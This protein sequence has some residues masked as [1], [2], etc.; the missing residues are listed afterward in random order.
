MITKNRHSPYNAEVR[1][2]EEKRQMAT[3]LE[4]ENADYYAESVIF[5]RF[6]LRRSVVVASDLLEVV[7]LGRFAP[8]TSGASRPA[9]FQ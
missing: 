1:T 9:T 7:R 8:R 4:K 5:G 2:D 3:K 6:L